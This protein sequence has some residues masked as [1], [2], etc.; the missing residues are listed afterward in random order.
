MHLQFRNFVSLLLLIAGISVAPTGFAQTPDLTLGDDDPVYDIAN[1]LM[2]E[3]ARLRGQRVDIEELLDAVSAQEN[4]VTRSTRELGERFATARQMVDFAS[5]SD[6]LGAILLAYWEGIDSYRL[7]DPTTQLSQNLGNT[8]ISRIN[9]EEALAE[10][11][12]VSAYIAGRIDDA[13]LDS[14]TIAEAS[15]DVLVELARSRRE[16]LRRIIEVESDYISALSELEADYTQLTTT[17]D[18]YEEY[19]GV[20]ILWKP[21]RQRLWKLD[22][23]ALPAEIKD[24]I[25]KLRETRA[26]IEPTAVVL[27]LFAGILFIMRRRMRDAQLVRNS[28]TQRP[29]SDSIRFTIV[30]LLLTVLRTLPATLLILAI[31][32]L[33]SWDSTSATATLPTAINFIAAVLFVL[34][35]TRTLCDENE[36]GRAHFGWRSNSCERWFEDASW[37]IRWWL[38]IAAVVAIVFMLA[39][40]TAAIGRL[41]LLLAIGVLIGRLVSNIRRGMQVSE[42]RWSIV[43]TNRLRLMFVALLIILSAGVFWGLRYSVGV[44]TESL[45][46]TVCIVIGLVLVHGLLMRW[47]QVVHRRLRF[48]ELRSLRSK[49][50]S[51]EID[52]IEEDRVGLLEISG[53]TTQL[54]HVLTMVATVVAL[55]YIW[56]PLLPAFDLLSEVTLWTSS[57]TVEGESVLTQITL[58]TLVVVIFLV[59][60][61]LVAARK[62]PALV[63]LVLRARTDV[64]AGVR[65]TTSTLMSYVII[66][67]GII[68][69]L[70]ALGLRWSELQWLIAA[71]GIGIGFGLQEIVADFIGGLIILFERPIRVGDIVTVDDQVGEV[72][73]IRIRATTIRD[74][75]GKELLVPNKN[76][77][78]GTL[79]NWSLSDSHMRMFIPVGVAYGSDVEQALEILGKIVADNPSVLKD[80]EPR[81]MFENFGD[82]ALE[83]SARFFLGEYHGWRDIVTELRREIYKRFTDAEIVIAFPQRDVHLDTEQP[84]R[85]VVDPPPTN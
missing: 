13:G 27:L 68:S 24:V 28:Q 5:E 61:T 65:Y 63:E 16:Q 48:A 66:G 72:S 42:W 34:T 85:I 75:D 44:I 81:V 80:P 84:I 51:G 29:R 6:A 69:A 4:A 2:M 11:A 12:D 40:A 78:S 37:L 45:L 39:D 35:F 56:A 20:L 70:S 55:L 43:T 54:L 50:A 10:S 33:F 41:T 60:V 18:D 14:A 74:R 36:V 21:S 73:K 46:T 31:G 25:G 82:N 79:V 77:I 32:T 62:L 49:K 59:S 83:L 64:T 8:V 53:A 17:I 23:R 47:L 3:N 76:F 58:E 52:T 9:H 71:L 38:P 19:L 7:A 26:T 15:R 57:S 67:I 22:P 30:A 1:V